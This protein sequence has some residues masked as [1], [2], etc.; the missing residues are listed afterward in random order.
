MGIHHCPDLSFFGQPWLK[1]ST[2]LLLLHRQQWLSLPPGNFSSRDPSLNRYTYYKT[3]ETRIRI[4]Q[5]KETKEETYVSEIVCPTIGPRSSVWVHHW[6]CGDYRVWPAFSNLSPQVGLKE[7]IGESP[8]TLH[9]SLDTP[10][11]KKKKE[12]HELGLDKSK[13]W[14]TRHN[15][16]TNDSLDLSKTPQVLSNPSGIISHLSSLHTQF[17][18]CMKKYLPF[19][20]RLELGIS[21]TS[22]SNGLQHT[23]LKKPLDAA[24]C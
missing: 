1:G 16:G 9:W 10:E 4:K 17:E 7:Y 24:I 23:K 12:W 5:G 6:K 20:S 15:A 11:L 22:L 14:W 18:P 3:E 19:Q 2:T 21:D 13:S 8:P